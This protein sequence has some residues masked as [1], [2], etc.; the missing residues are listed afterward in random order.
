V[1]TTA[2]A[3]LTLSRGQ[4]VN[5]V[6]VQPITRRHSPWSAHDG[7]EEFERF[8][9]VLTRIMSGGRLAVLT[10]SMRAYGPPPDPPDGSGG[11]RFGTKDQEYFDNPGSYSMSLTVTLP[12]SAIVGLESLRAKCR[13]GVPK[14]WGLLFGTRQLIH[15]LAAEAHVDNITIAEPIQLPRDNRVFRDLLAR[16]PDRRVDSPYDPQGIWRQML[17]FGIGQRMGD[18]HNRWTFDEDAHEGNFFASKGTVIRCDFAR[19]FVAYR[20]LTALQAATTLMP[21]LSSFSRVDW[22]WFMQGYV[23]TRGN[24]ALKVIELID[25]GSIRVRS[26]PP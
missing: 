24:D 25:P 4:R 20:P 6:L 1:P 7:F 10:A 11:G 19:S 21:L 17:T 15:R 12:G 22:Y 26:S 13:P 16:A 2:D 3:T 14:R 18:M 8:L 5:A 9:Q 23:A